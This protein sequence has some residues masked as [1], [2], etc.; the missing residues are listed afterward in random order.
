MKPQGWGHGYLERHGV[1]SLPSG[2]GSYSL[3]QRSVG[4]CGGVCEGGAEGEAQRW[5]DQQVGTTVGPH[6][7]CLSFTINVCSQT[8]WA[9]V[10]MCVLHTN[11]GLQKQKYKQWWRRWQALPWWSSSKYKSDFFSGFSRSERSEFWP[12]CGLLH[13]ISNENIQEAAQLSKIKYS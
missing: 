5:S 13:Y 11:T 12:T 2:I 6:L 1:V 9:C 4:V 7:P 3:G 10:T 8:V